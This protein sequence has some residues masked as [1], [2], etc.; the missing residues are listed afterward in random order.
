MLRY[1]SS[2]V[3]ACPQ[4]AATVERSMCGILAS[5]NLTGTSKSAC[6]L[7]CVPPNPTAA[8]APTA[9]AAAALRLGGPAIGGS[10]GLA[11]TDAVTRTRVDETRRIATSAVT[12]PVH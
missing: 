4:A 1:P 5:A 3:A 12:A 10:A 8:G 2:R 9:T 7:L 6:Q 11:L